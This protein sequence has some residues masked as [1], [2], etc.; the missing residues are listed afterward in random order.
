MRTEETY[1]LLQSAKEIRVAIET[2]GERIGGASGE[3]PGPLTRRLA[4][5]FPGEAADS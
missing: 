5:A 1:S 2:D 3:A 4:E